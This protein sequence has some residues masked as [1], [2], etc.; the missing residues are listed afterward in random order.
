MSRVKRIVRTIEKPKVETSEGPG[1]TIRVRIRYIYIRSQ[2]RKRTVMPGKQMENCS[3]PFVRDND[4]FQSVPISF[5]SF[6]NVLFP[7]IIILNIE[8]RFSCVPTSPLLVLMDEMGCNYTRFYCSVLYFLHTIVQ[9]V[10]SRN[11]IDPGS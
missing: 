6:W 9:Q 2:S 4:A 1:C 8:L 10:L 11:I 7:V 3:A 5:L